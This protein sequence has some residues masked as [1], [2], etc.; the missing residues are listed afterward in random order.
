MAEQDA[1]AGAKVLA[2]LAQRAHE[3]VRQCKRSCARA[4][5]AEA[6]VGAYVQVWTCVRPSLA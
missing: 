1:V 4:R 2:A 6:Y 3:R 5:R